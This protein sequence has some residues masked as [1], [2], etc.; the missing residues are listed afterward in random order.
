MKAVKKNGKPLA[1]KNQ[2]RAIFTLLIVVPILI[3][4][5]YVYYASRK[6]LIQQTRITMTGNVDVIATGLENNCKRENDVIKFFSYKEEFRKAL[7]HAESDQYGLANELNNDI[8][9]LIWYYLSSDAN[10]DAIH[11][12]SDLIQKEHIGN[13]LS[14]PLTDD[15]KAIYELCRENYSYMWVTDSQGEVYVVKSLL[16]ASTSSK[17]VGVVTLKVKDG[18][19]FSMIS[20][21]GYLDNGVLVVDSDNDIIIHKKI[22]NENLDEKI[23]SGLLANEIAF[24]SDKFF[25]SR[26]YFIAASKRLENGWYLY[27]YIDR[28]EITSDVVS[29]LVTDIIIALVLFVI[30][31]FIATNYSKHLSQRIGSL[32]TMAGEIKG[33]RLD[34]EDKDDYKDEIGQL[35]ESMTGMADQLRAMMEEVNKRNEQDLLMKESDIHYREWLFDFVVEKN[36]D[37]LAVLGEDGYS[38]S[39][40][41]SNVQE[42]LGIS[43]E[44]LKQDIRCLELAVRQDIQPVESIKDVIEKC[45]ETGEAKIL[46]E[47]RL[48][49]IKN[50]EH[51]YYRGVIVSTIDDGGK[52]MAIA[53][54]DRTQEFRRNHQLQEALNAA[55]TANRAKTSF[56]ANMSHDFRTPMNAITGF[57]LLI[58]K[59]SEEPEKVR[60]YT[61]KISLASQNLLSLLN[62]VLDMSKIESGKTTLD[63]KEMAIGL[64]IEEINSVISF[65]AKAKNQEYIVRVEDMEHD[66]FLGDKQRINEILVNILG[67]AVK[68]TPEGGRIEFTID[69]SSSSSVGFQNVRFTIKDNGIG[70]KPEYKDKIFDAFSRE[71]KGATKGIQGTGLGMAITK[72]LVELMGGTIRVESEEGKGS[73]FV[74]NLRLQIV[75]AADVDFWRAHGISRILFVDEKK[76]TYEQF[77]NI[78]EPDGVEVLH[79]NSPYAAL[80]KIDDCDNEQKVIDIILVDEVVEGM[81][82]AEIIRSIRSKDRRNNVLIFVMTDD[83]GRIEDDV[84][85][86]GGNE[87]LQKPLFVSI[88]KQT[89]E[90]IGNRNAAASQTEVKNPL[91]GMKFLAAEDNDINA[92]IL[93]ELMN[94]EGATVNRGINGQEVVEM[95]KAA[96]EGDYDMILMDIQMPIMNGYEA[97]AAIRALGTDWSQRIPIIAMT[98]NAYADDVQ[99]AFDAGMNAHVSKP[100]DIKVVEKTILE[101]KGK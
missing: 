61:H 33:G 92:D 72:S 2:L 97:A 98:A 13:F 40:I 95:F 76:D 21:T 30:S 48:E 29:I 71:D 55:E 93:I 10:I 101:F 3:L 53:L 87:L 90:D 43:L 24:D 56:L 64:L 70:M 8:E 6:N 31:F 82:A 58:D 17:V 79:A 78:L 52:R 63:I 35:S 19:F 65:Q 20:Q 1:L 36:N 80:R 7:E 37:I 11:I 46:D 57:N 84:R 96:N 42:V 69:E 59:H 39:F 41:T 22:A 15:E 14:M 88:F 49:N 54:Y 12:Y 25:A 60:E 89:V 23:L 94:M 18:S 9:P 28:N 91:E 83:F 26:E 81:V 50:N 38:P 5:I 73:T 74:V 99:H 85:A 32:N 34:V 86:A 75:D 44:L 77:K 4:G 16:D 45:M 68:Y 100:I 67:N 66:M 47:I 51:L 27:Y 62:D